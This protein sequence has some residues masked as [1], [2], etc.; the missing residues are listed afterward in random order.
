MTYAQ[1]I[2]FIT[3]AMKV[4]GYWVAQNG[5]PPY[6]GIPLP[7]QGDVATFYFYTQA[8]GGVPAPP[9][10]WNAPATRGWFA[11]ALWQALYSRYGGARI[12]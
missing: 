11:M 6:A 7:H 5:A 1:T 9:A 10:D 2:S 8:L 3:R 12:P 4:K